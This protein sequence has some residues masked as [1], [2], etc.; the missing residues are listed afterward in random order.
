MTISASQSLDCSDCI[1][2]YEIT[3]EE[4]TCRGSEREQKDKLRKF[5]ANVRTK[6]EDFYCKTSMMSIRFSLQTHFEK[7]RLND[8]DFKASNT[9][10]EAMLVK[11]TAE[12]K[13][14]TSQNSPI[15]L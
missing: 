13:D 8:F 10:F 4:D 1:I 15:L 3:G 11:I 5:Y 12:R 14:T 2:R 7:L 9:V 6:K